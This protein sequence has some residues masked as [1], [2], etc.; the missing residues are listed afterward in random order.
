MATKLKAQ[1]NTA[2]APKAKPIAS[3]SA[4]S[5]KPLESKPDAAAKETKPPKPLHPPLDKMT[6]AYWEEVMRIAIAPHE[7]IWRKHAKPAA[8]PGLIA[9]QAKNGVDLAK[10]LLEMIGLGDWPTLDDCIPKGS[11]LD[12]V[13][14]IFYEKTDL[15]RELPFYITV[16]YL[17]SLLLQQGVII[18]KS[19]TQVIYPDLWTIVMVGSGGGKTLTLNA[20]SNALG[21]KLKMFDDADSFPAFFDNLVAGNKSFF[22]KDEFAKFIRAVNRDPKMAGLQGCL[23][24][25]YSNS[26]VKRGLKND[27]PFVETP[28]LTILGLTQIAN[29]TSTISKSMLEDG[30]AQRFGYVYGEKDARPRV[31][32]YV[33]DEL[34]DEVSP[35]WK[36]L[37]A[38]PFHAVYR[39][40][41]V[42]SKT[43]AEGGKIIMDRSDA[44]GITEDFSRRV[45]FRAFK[46][47]LI[48]HVLTGKTDEYLHASDMAYGLM[49][50]ARE[51]RDT[52]RLLG[53][54]DILH[55]PVSAVRPSESATAPSPSKPQLIN[56]KNPVKGQ[57]LSYQDHVEKAKKKIVD[58]SAKGMT[59]NTRNLGSYVKVE[60]SILKQIL[61]ELAQDPVYAPHITLPKA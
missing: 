16:Q 56:K 60:V 33:L 17:A 29:I 35:L 20:I 8:R 36:Q 15:P 55:P 30:F 26:T 38:T 6:D 22:L 46:Y 27:A 40:D 18:Q 54:F 61:N 34:G 48:Y 37:T 57:P 59:T 14:R 47:A 23:L 12:A 7:T 21:G 39:L 58:F 3:A 4:K 1:T 41:D 9:E 13:D 5:S 44:L 32:D 53:E 42:V 43:W 31:L 52:T 49:L 11:I 51:M 28:A 24:N 2:Q 19:K 25:I 45:L 10:R 50:C